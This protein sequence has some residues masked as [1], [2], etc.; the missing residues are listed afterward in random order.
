MRLNLPNGELYVESHQ[1]PQQKHFGSGNETKMIDSIVHI[2]MILLST[3]SFPS[4]TSGVLHMDRCLLFF[5]MY[6]ATQLKF[7]NPSTL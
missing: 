4:C 2:I 5:T 3:S 7:N 1:N 6:H